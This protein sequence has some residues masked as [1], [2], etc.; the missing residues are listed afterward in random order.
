MIHFQFNTKLV[1]EF[2][3]SPR[4][5]YKIPNYQRAYSWEQP[6]W[7]T[8]LDDIREQLGG[9]NSYFF[10]NVM[11]ETV[12]VGKEYEII[13][14]QQRLT[15]LVIFMRALINIL[16]AHAD[17][18]KNFGNDAVPDNLEQWY[19]KANGNIKLHVVNYDQNF[20]ENCIIDDD[21]NLTMNSGSQKRMKEAKSFFMKE[22]KGHD[23]KTLKEILQKIE[24]TNLTTIELT[25]KKDATLMFELQNDRGKDLTNME[26]LKAYL[27]YQTYLNSPR[28]ETEA[29]IVYISG[30]F[31]KIYQIIFDLKTLDEDSVLLYHCYAHLKQGF[32]YRNISEIKDELKVSK[33]H[34]KWIV[35]FVNELHETF[36]NLRDLEDRSSSFQY[37]ED[38]RNLEMPPFVYPFIIRGYKYLA[39]P[40]GKMEEKMNT[41]LHILEVVAFRHQ[42]IHSRADLSGRLNDPLRNFAGDLKKLRNDLRDKFNEKW[43]WGDGHVNDFLRSDGKI[44]GNKIANYLLW[45]YEHNL[46]KDYARTSIENEQ[47]EHILPQTEP[48][49]S[50]AAGYDVPDEDLD[51]YLHCFGNLMLISKRHNSSIGNK[52]FKEKLNRILKI[53]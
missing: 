26:R 45:K 32:N 13:D 47:I 7:Q 5:R 35:D 12:K 25:G 22:L 1:S 11:L 8:F 46:S 43:Y 49:D 34:I 23:T 16:R 33:N 27:M 19:L 10:G 41:L 3:E 39:D 40:K 29:N 17:N 14:G 42:L 36:R 44:Y 18:E 31:E 24:D 6:N 30:I 38:I 28:D 51:E 21:D 53:H 50:I 37:Y 9:E 2:F 15:T 4:K 20:F 48:D 52:P